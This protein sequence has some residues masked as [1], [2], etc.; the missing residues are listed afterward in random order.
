[1]EFDQAAF[2][3]IGLETA[4]PLTLE[5]VRQDVLSLSRAIAALSTIPANLLGVPGGTLARGQTADLILIDLEKNWTVKAGDL[6]SLSKNTPFLGRAMVG[7]AV[8]T[9]IQGHVVF[10]LIN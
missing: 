6:R 7:R 5:L 10:T 4:L 3:I 2:G 8:L 1:M 9:M